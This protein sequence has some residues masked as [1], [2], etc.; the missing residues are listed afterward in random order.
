M[1]I[2]FIIGFSFEGR[3]SLS[4]TQRYRLQNDVYVPKHLPWKSLRLIPNNLLL[5]D[6]H[7]KRHKKKR[8]KIHFI[9]S[10]L[11]KNLWEKR[12]LLKKQ[13][14]CLKSDV[15]QRNADHEV[16]IC[17]QSSGK[18]R[19]IL[20]I[21]LQLMLKNENEKL[22]PFQYEDSKTQIKRRTS[23][24]TFDPKNVKIN[25]I[26]GWERRRCGMLIWCEKVLG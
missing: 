25:Q 19:K 6:Q 12:F 5:S 23:N 16:C 20:R 15:L 9:L 11:K 22:P 3:W 14:C 17:C 1:R 7:R 26:S 4:D 10:F 2:R 24:K 13:F 8:P 21:I 18:L